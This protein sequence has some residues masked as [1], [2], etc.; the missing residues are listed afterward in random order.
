METIY[1]DNKVHCYIAFLITV[2]IPEVS[3]VD[4]VLEKRFEPGDS[5]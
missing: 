3:F 2:P 1:I 4:M 5:E